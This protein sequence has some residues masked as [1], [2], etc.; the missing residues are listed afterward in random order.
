MIQKITK[1]MAVEITALTG[2]SKSA[3]PETMDTVT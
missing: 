1:K 2:V 3:L